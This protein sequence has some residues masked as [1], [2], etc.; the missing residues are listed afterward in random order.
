[1]QYNTNN[2]VV[3]T[4]MISCETACCCAGTVRLRRTGAVCL[5]TVAVAR[6]TRT[7]K[8]A[9]PD[10]RGCFQDPEV[11]VCFLPCLGSAAV[12]WPGLQKNERIYSL[13]TRQEYA[14]Y[15]VVYTTRRRVI[16]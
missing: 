5:P 16:T 8:A 3:Y 13:L 15:F 14:A 2:F 4:Y 10:I 7:L 1:M 11:A 9:G 12:G 6:T